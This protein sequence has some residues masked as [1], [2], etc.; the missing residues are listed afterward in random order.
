MI[1]EKHSVTFNEI[2][3]DPQELFKVFS[4]YFETRTVLA[5]T[6]L[7]KCEI[8][9]VNTACGT[10]VKNFPEVRKLMNYFPI[11]EEEDK[12]CPE[13]ARVFYHEYGTGIPPHIDEQSS[14]AIL[15]PICP[16]PIDPVIYLNAG[17]KKQFRGSWWEP[18][19]FNFTDIEWIHQYRFGHPSLINNLIPHTIKNLNTES[20]RAI[21]RF[22]ISVA[23][24][25]QC[26]EMCEKG[27]FLRI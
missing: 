19:E 2:T 21:L 26:R 12:I 18:E 4:P 13:L 7:G 8:V 22:R 27:T 1:F 16:W 25:Y 5:T 9:D 20:P 10:S 3:Y 17:D 6:T 24:Y 15:F 14:A 11:L 23:D